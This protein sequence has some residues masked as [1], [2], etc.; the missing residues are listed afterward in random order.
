MRGWH[1]G[2]EAI[3]DEALYHENLELAA[4]CQYYT[5]FI[6][7]KICISF[8]E[9]Q[10]GSDDVKTAIRFVGFQGVHAWC[11][12][13]TVHS[14]LLFT[15]AFM[16]HHIDTS[17]SSETLTLAKLTSVEQKVSVIA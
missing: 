16:G 10:R 14:V 7:S 8:L 4:I 17:N 3:T 15:L 11:I 2:A 5:V 9:E 13:G 1:I 12:V 6:F